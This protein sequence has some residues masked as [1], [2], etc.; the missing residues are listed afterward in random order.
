M[1]HQFQIRGVSLA[2]ERQGQGPAFV[3]AHMG[4]HSRAVENKTGLFDWSSLQ[5]SMEVIR[6]DARGHGMSESSTSPRYFTY[7]SLALD[8]VSLLDELRVTDYWLGGASLGA[9]TVM[10]AALL[11]DKPPAG[12]V[13][14]LPPRAWE[15]RRE[16]TDSY[17]A[18]ATQF[19]REGTATLRGSIAHENPSAFFASH[20]HLVP[21]AFD[22]T[23]E[24][25]ALMVRRPDTDLPSRL[26]LATLISPA[27]IL[28]WPN[29]TNHPESVAQEV[30]RLLPN[31]QLETAQVAGDVLSWPARVRGFIKQHDKRM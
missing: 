26:R 28:A 2:V 23:D 15:G 5:S 17:S 8:L 30:S 16:L 3:W 25:L 20:P 27:L 7:E 11:L 14:A 9:A 13:I 24:T 18:L 10:H 29:D 19:E 31:A 21:R 12:L 22:L 4:G 1:E 6:Y